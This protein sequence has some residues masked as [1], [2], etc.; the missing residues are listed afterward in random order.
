[1]VV[2]TAGSDVHTSEEDYAL[3]DQYAMALNY[4]ADFDNDNSFPNPIHGFTD[5]YYVDGG[6]E[7]LM[8]NN[9]FSSTDHKLPQRTI[10]SA[11]GEQFDLNFHTG[12]YS[13][14]D[15]I[16]FFISLGME[17]VIISEQ[18]YILCKTPDGSVAQGIIT[19]TAPSKTGSYEIT[20]VIINNPF[21]TKIENWT[22][23]NLSYRF[24]LCVS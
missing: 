8:L 13:D 16:L 21:E 17:Q 10:Y 12:G 15:T 14:G 23:Q 18:N 3:S 11:A 6:F 20:G 1:M 4:I 7:G 22:P 19:L 24:T 5:V 2:L 9:D